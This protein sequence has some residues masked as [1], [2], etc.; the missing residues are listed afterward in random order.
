M[1]D[2]LLLSVWISDKTLLLVFGHQ[3]KHSSSCLTCK[4]SVFGY[5]KDQALRRLLF[6]ISLLGVWVTNKYSFLCLIYYL[7]VFGYLLKW[8]FLLI[9]L[10][11]WK[12]VSD[13]SFWC[14]DIRWKNAAY[15]VW[16]VSLFGYQIKHS[17][18]FLIYYLEVYGY[19]LK[20]S[21]A[22]WFSPLYV[23]E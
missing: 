1:F 6:K 19:L 12:S 2:K 11:V 14:L 4:F 17:F 18:S 8:L 16:P 22:C 13:I 20:H 5:Q 15:R 21:F 3:M 7:S 9:Y 10:C 23:W